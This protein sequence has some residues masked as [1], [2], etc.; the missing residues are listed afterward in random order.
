V[1]KSVAALQTL[2]ANVLISDLKWAQ[3]DRNEVYDVDA[4]PLAGGQGGVFRA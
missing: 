1:G 3:L 4:V 2:N